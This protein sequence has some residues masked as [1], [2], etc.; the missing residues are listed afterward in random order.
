MKLTQWLLMGTGVAI[1]VIAL[2]SC[3]P[4]PRTEEMR[5]I[6]LESAY[7]T[8]GQE[9]LQP[10][11]RRLDEP[12]GKALDQMYQG[13]YG[14]GTSNLLL[15]RGEDITAAVKATRWAFLGGRSADMP[16]DPEDGSMGGSLWVVVYFGTAGSG[17]P[18]WLVHGI[19]V[20]GRT[21]RVTFSKPNR[22]VSTADVHQYFLWAPLGHVEPGAFTLELYDAEKTD[23]ALLRHVTIAEK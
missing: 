16:V 18:A 20:K 6:P 12:C 19:E 4:A 1:G 2:S 9:G 10:V 5:L 8:N 14:M 3:A 13:S 21:V 7:S 23:V 15:V 17:P 11:L 22:P